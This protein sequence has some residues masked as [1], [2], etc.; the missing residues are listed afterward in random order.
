MSER[1]PQWA[2]EPSYIAGYN[3]GASVVRAE[4]E[5]ERDALRAR[6]AELQQQ[7]AAAQRKIENRG[8][9]NDA[10]QQ[11]IADLRKE[12]AAARAER[13]YVPDEVKSVIALW[14]NDIASRAAAFLSLNPQNA[15]GT[16]Y[17]MEVQVIDA[18]LDS[19]VDVQGS[20]QGEE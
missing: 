16:K 4:L 5:A 2:D 18:W 11:E 19:L 8:M 15:Q 13:R 10:Y 7:L 3:D 12:L 20:E 1:K 14:R 6:V 9:A 17:Q